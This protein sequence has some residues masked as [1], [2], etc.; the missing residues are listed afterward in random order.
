MPSTMVID[1]AARI[2]AGISSLAS[3]PTT[4]PT[5]AVHR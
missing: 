3:A 4:K 2:P 5:I 1:E